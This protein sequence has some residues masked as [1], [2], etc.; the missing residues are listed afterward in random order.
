[1]EVDFACND[2][3]GEFTGKAE[4]IEIGELSLECT[5]L[6]SGVA[7]RA[8]ALTKRLWV[9]RLRMPYKAYKYGVG[10]WCWDGYDLYE[11]DVLKIINYLEKQ[12]YW[13][14]NEGPS[15]L[16]EKFNRKQAFTLEELRALAATEGTPTVGPGR[17]GEGQ[18]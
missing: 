3:R 9:G 7:M 11:P 12:K 4:R 2:E 15:E 17:Q 10:N 8:D 13:T 18:G 1:M 16:Y 6:Y 5:L 14:C